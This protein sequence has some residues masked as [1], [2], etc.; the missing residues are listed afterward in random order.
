MVKA[1]RR[2]LKLR[3]DQI[4]RRRLQICSGSKWRPKTQESER[5]RDRHKMELPL[6]EVG[7]TNFG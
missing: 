1:S 5:E 4:G 3:E 6:T 7:A 2:G